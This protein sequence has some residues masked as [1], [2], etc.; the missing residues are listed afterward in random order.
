MVRCRSAYSRGVGVSFGKRS[1]HY[2]FHLS[3]LQ[4]RPDPACKL[5]HITWCATGPLSSS[6]IHA[7]GLYGPD[8]GPESKNFNYVVSSYTPTL[9]ALLAAP[10][11]NTTA[12][13][14]HGM[15]AVSD[16]SLQGTAPEMECIQRHMGDMGLTWLDKERSTVD[17]VLDGMGNHSWVHLACHPCISTSRRLYEKRIQAI[18]REPIVDG[19]YE[20][21]LQARPVCLPLGLSDGYG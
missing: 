19:Y 21:A 20:A 9:S 15:L 5:P 10:Q 16:S 6:P 18:R 4:Q 14:F 1:L 12:S 2:I 11:A 3:Q 7:A 8:H 17:A 13:N